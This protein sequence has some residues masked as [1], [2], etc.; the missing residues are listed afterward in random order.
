MKI[1]SQFNYESINPD[2]NNDIHLVVELSAPKTDAPQSRPPI[3]IIP[4]VDTSG[5]MTGDKLEFAKQSICKLID[6]L[7]PTDLAGLVTFNSVVDVVVPVALMT[8]ENKQNFKMKVNA[9]KAGGG[10]ALSGGM[11]TALK[12]ME[13]IDVSVATL[14][15]VILFT[16]GEANVGPRSAREISDLLPAALGSTSLSCFG[17]GEGADQILLGSLAEAGRGNYAFI[18]DPDSAPTAFAKELGGLLSVHAHNIKLNLIPKGCSIKSI[19]SDVSANQHDGIGT[20]V[21]WLVSVPELLCEEVR[22]IVV[23]VTVPK[24][25]HPGPVNLIGI[26]A[27]WGV[28]NP[29]ENVES[30]LSV[31]I[32]LDSSQKNVAADKTVEEV[33]QLAKMIRAQID[34][35]KFAEAGD[36]KS[37]T[38]TMGMFSSDAKL[39]GFSK[40]GLFADK[41]ADV[42]GNSASYNIGKG[43]LRST[44]A[45]GTRSFTTASVDADAV[46][47]LGEALDSCEVGAANAAQESLVV[48]FN[49]KD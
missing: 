16:D 48:E 3:A 42:F 41:T 37:A 1:K 22:R 13:R 5:S 8:P 21:G 11:L 24:G 7:S 39:H 40:L 38:T 9:L 15:R 46:S 4:T 18:K 27:T 33:V 43:R 26:N 6:H 12:E 14:S 17:Y 47:A 32:E 44:Q 35:T 31:S 10:T 29:P 45:V 49:K 30:T 28:L 23:A 2:E 36:Y 34:A 25:K 19:V 20:N